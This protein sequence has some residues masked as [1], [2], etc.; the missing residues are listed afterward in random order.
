MFLTERK[1]NISKSS[2]E[3][4]Q[5]RLLGHMLGIINTHLCAKNLKK[6]MIKSREKAQKLVFPVFSAGIEFFPEIMLGHILDIT[7]L[8][9]CAKNQKKLMSQSREKLVTDK[10]T[11]ERTNIS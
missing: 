1:R 5:K 3:N 7:I 10:R 8:H 11:N 9:L 2:D 6:V 4:L